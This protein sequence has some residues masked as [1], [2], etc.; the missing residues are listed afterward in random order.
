M[1][2][3]LL[4]CPLVV[5]AF[6]GCRLAYP[7]DPQALLQ[8]HPKICGPRGISPA[9]QGPDPRGCY[10]PRLHGGFPAKGALGAAGRLPP[11]TKGKGRS[12]LATWQRPEGYLGLQ[13]SEPPGAVVPII[14]CF[15]RSSAQS[16]P[17]WSPASQPVSSWTLS[18]LPF[19]IGLG[20]GEGGAAL[21]EE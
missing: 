4:L 11:K 14:A 21:V 6:G 18:L 15:C 16:P 13:V 10:H 3:R 1:F 12:C 20:S 9:L 2:R 19:P 7:S 5:R 8:P 17:D